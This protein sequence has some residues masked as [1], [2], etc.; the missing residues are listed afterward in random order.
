MS[1]RHRMIG[2]NEHMI[3]DLSKVRQGNTMTHFGLGAIL[4]GQQV[5]TES[6]LWV[7]NLVNHV[8]FMLKDQE[9]EFSP[10]SVLLFA[11]DNRKLA[12]TFTQSVEVFDPSARHFTALDTSTGLVSI[13]DSKY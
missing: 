13:V 6:V 9:S 12:T 2:D 5:Q 10:A 3:G 11:Y 4:H 8:L 7:Q 1:F